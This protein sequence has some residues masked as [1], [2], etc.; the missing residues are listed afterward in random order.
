MSELGFVTLDGSIAAGS[1]M[2]PQ[3]KNPDVFE[4]LRGSAAGAIGDVTAY[5]HRI[6]VDDRQTS[7]VA[8]A[9]EAFQGTPTP[10][11]VTP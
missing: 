9:D 5:V 10:K 6:A 8:H 4:L 11:V 1:S 7:L 2:M 3:K